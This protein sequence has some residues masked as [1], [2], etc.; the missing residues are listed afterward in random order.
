MLS[1]IFHLRVMNVMQFLICRRFWRYINRRS[2]EI[3]LRY[4]EWHVMQR[5]EHVVDSIIPG[6]DS[7]SIFKPQRLL[8]VPLEEL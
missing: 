3:E 8:A 7:S 5:A 1:V 4:A 2:M 6:Q